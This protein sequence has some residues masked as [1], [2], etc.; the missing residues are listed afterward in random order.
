MDRWPGITE[1]AGHEGYGDMSN[2]RNPETDPGE[3]TAY[4]VRI[5]G[6]L[7]IQSENSEGGAP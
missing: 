7:E 6:H 1:M 2:E 3:P 4:Q 5:K